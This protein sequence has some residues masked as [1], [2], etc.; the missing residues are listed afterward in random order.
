MNIEDRGAPGIDVG[1]AFLLGF[2]PTA[3]GIAFQGIT[4]AGRAET[5]G[6]P[7]LQHHGALVA[8]GL[9]SKNGDTVHDVLHVEALLARTGHAAPP[10]P[11]DLEGYLRWLG[12]VRRAAGQVAA[13]MSPE[14]AALMAGYLVAE[15][16]LLLGLG[17]IALDLLGTLP[18]D[19]H[20]RA[21]AAHL[22]S[23]V[24]GALAKLRQVLRHPAL[25]T[26]VA[27]ACASV[28]A[29]AEGA[30][31]IDDL[32][33]PPQTRMRGV[34]SALATATRALAPLRTPARPGG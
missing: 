26:P 11:Q 34:Q 24:P 33:W 16:Y 1:E 17:F 30:P 13:P 18:E 9:R 5:S 29:A 2:L 31:A 22:G 4:L 27:M 8:Q 7:A 32:A 6:V 23:M 28:L 10:R 15:A 12:A 20:N 14:G 3:C 21:Q 25:P 19:V